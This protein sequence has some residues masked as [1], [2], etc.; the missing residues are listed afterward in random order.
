M[1]HPRMRPARKFEIGIA[2]GK[3]RTF[4]MRAPDGSVGDLLI[5]FIQRHSGQA[6]LL[7]AVLV[8]DFLNYAQF[9]LYEDDLTIIP[10][11]MGMDL[12]ELA[13]FIVTYIVNLHGHGRPLQDSFIHLFSFLGW[14][15]GGLHVIY[16]IGYAIVALNVLLFYGLLKRIGNELL[17]ISG[18]LA[19]AL[20]PANTTQ[21]FLHHS[22]GLHP[23]L[24]FFLLAAHAHLSGRKIISFLLILGS[25]FTR[26]T[27]FPVFLAMPLLSGPYDRKKASELLRH[28]LVI[29]VLLAGV[30][31]LRLWVGDTR[32]SGLGFPDVLLTPLRHM[33][34]GPFV[35]IAMFFYRP[36]QT[37]QNLSGEVL[38]LT[39]AS[40]V[41]L[42]WYFNRLTVDSSRSTDL[43]MRSLF[44]VPRTGRSV[45][46]EFRRR[47]ASLSPQAKALTKLALAGVA[48]LV[49]AYPL[50]FNIRSFSISGRDTRIHFAAIVGASILFAC[51]AT[52]ILSLDRTRRNRWIAVGFISIWLSLLAGSGRVVQS[53]YVQAWSAQQAFWSDLV[54][55]IPDVEQGTVILLEPSGLKDFEQIDA[56]T[57]N[58]PRVLNQL[59][60]FPPEWEILPRV[61]RLVPGWRNRILA[62]DGT[63]SLYNLTVTAPPSLYRR[64]E[65]SQVIVIE[66]RSGFLTRSSGQ[67]E[68]GGQTIA[69][70]R[71]SEP[72]LPSLQPGFL[73]Q[74]MMADAPA[75]QE[76]YLIKP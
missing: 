54:E 64:V 59:Y 42:A 51:A 73:H 10:G 3:F 16:W 70:K 9:G 27:V 21:P 45:T 66:T 62:A 33:I 43:R 5:T 63:L 57:W 36:I 61:Y 71:R 6:L 50:T 30:V 49:L 17:A 23:A 20:F 8:T 15:L 75:H 52:L 22:L 24:T 60:E 46:V 7:G 13:Q 65:P 14:R 72:F 2:C 41:L 38:V 55:L 37:I 12:S 68:V 67:L 74:F 69:L 39:V 11:A 25:L 48:M 32:V 58:L 31:L 44:R 18:A 29:G 40:L 35:T 34:V 26:E 4:D 56:N 28:L 53:D 76:A 19:F 47:L 1:A